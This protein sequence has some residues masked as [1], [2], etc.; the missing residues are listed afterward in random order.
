MKLRTL[1]ALRY[2]SLM[3]FE[4][5]LRSLNLLIGRNAAGKS[6]ILD[7]LRFLSEAM[8]EKDFLGPVLGRGNFVQLAWK[9]E[10][11]QEI[12][13]ETEFEND[14]H[15][16]WWRVRLRRRAR[17]FEVDEESLHRG[18][19]GARPEELLRSRRGTGS[20]Y[21]ESGRV[22]LSI[23]STG[24]ALAAA[25]ADESFPG[26]E[27]ARFVRE[28]GFF[29]PSPGYLRLATVARDEGK[30][31]DT[32]G[33]NL[34]GRL[35]EISQKDPAIFKRIVEAV[36]AVLG[37]PDEV[38]P[39]ISEDGDVYFLQNEANLMF[40]VHQKGVSAGT[41][42]MLAL[43]TALLGETEASLVGI[44]EPENYIHPSALAAFAQ[45][46]QE[47]TQG[48]QVLITTHSPLLLNY[49]GDP[50]AVCIV[51]ITDRGTQAKREDNSEGVR[52]ALEESG[53]GLGDFHETKG[54]GS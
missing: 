10:E 40:R 52:R 21:S 45:Y 3:D 28:W 34:A 44:E 17:D 46:V 39:R 42:R 30:R 5:Q 29:D 26:G 31:L 36:R 4:I 47:A 49:L 48:V 50:E 43:M 37:V 2:R 14:N 11:A 35:Y 41:L 54:F 13:L 8:Q 1:K 12:E 33:R 24:C 38:E 15:T 25:A 32:F 18:G 9:G 27:V 51:R 19:L 16:F 22:P 6:N 23:T 7:A 20:W 53:F